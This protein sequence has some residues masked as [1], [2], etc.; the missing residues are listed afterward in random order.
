MSVSA[1]RFADRPLRSVVGPEDGPVLVVGMGVTGCAVARALAAHGH[2]VIVADDRP[3]RATR[4]AEMAGLTL[5]EVHDSTEVGLLSSLVI[6][7]AAV[8][9]A[10]GVPPRH[11]CYRLADASST[12]VVSEL[13]LAAQWDGRPVAAVT[14]TNGKTTV[15]TLIERM[16]NRSGISAAAAGNTDVALVDAISEDVDTFV[17]E[18]SS[19][20]LCRTRLFAP[21]VAVWLNLAP[22]HLDWHPDFGDYAACKARIWAHQGPGDVAVAPYGDPGIGPRTA[23][24]EARNV[25]F[26]AAD[27]LGAPADVRFEAGMLMAFGSPLVDVAALPRKRPH[28]L[29]N[30][31]AATAAALEMGA[32]ADAVV[33]GLRSFAGLAHRLAFAGRVGGVSFYDDSKATAPHATVAALT[34]FSDAILIA[35]GRNKGLDL[36]DLAEA[37]AH[38]RGVVAIGESADAVI[39]SFGRLR[40]HHPEMR[41]ADSMPEAVELAY[42]MALPAGDVVLSPGCASFDWYSSYRDRG[43][44]FIA[45]VTELRVRHDELAQREGQQ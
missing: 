35:G 10:P 29:S 43:Q 22:D 30:A 3:D 20:R 7:A 8:A 14:G 33:A 21:A 45:S 16:L 34:G 11:P 6:R 41:R 27:A 31:A 26:A 15:T 32:S 36:S 19:F 1:L 12:P 39:G 44:H 40:P 17:V 37:A 2:E 42:R 9:P 23:G 38:V 5:T 18:A 24:I 13:D 28:D 4:A 25:T